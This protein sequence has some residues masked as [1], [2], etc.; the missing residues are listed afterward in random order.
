MACTRG[1]VEG[2]WGGER[3]SASSS[4]PGAEEA[5]MSGGMGTGPVGPTPLAARDSG[6]LDLQG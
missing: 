1:Q 2:F 6:M 3:A 5:Q 4:P